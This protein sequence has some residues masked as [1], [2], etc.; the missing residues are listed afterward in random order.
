MSN[1]GI[2]LFFTKINKDGERWEVFITGFGEEKKQVY[3]GFF[4]WWG[5]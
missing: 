5:V 4:T 3:V 1:D 2:V